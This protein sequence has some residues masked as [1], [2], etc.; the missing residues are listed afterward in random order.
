MCGNAHQT[1]EDVNPNWTPSIFFNYYW[2]DSNYIYPISILKYLLITSLSKEHP[3]HVWQASVHSRV[4][5]RG[6]SKSGLDE[7]KMKSI[8]RPR[9]T[10]TGRP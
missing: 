7:V 9:K 6:V 2:L 4:A 8:S 1:F 5:A 10:H 3:I